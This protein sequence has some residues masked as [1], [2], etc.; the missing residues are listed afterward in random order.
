MGGAATISAPADNS[1]HFLR[2][3]VTNPRPGHCNYRNSRYP[4][5]FRA[6]RLSGTALAESIRGTRYDSIMRRHSEMTGPLKLLIRFEWCLKTNRSPTRIR[7]EKHKMKSPARKPSIPAK[8][9]AA[10]PQNDGRARIRTG[11]RKDFFAHR[12]IQC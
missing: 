12:M 2:Q 3:I 6:L 1:A 11:W 7:K 5:G 9:E 10:V 4:Q 8:E